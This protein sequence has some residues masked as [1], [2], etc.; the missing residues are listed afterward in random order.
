[1]NSSPKKKFY[2]TLVLGV[3]FVFALIFVAR[4]FL[5]MV[6]DSYTELSSF[7]DSKENFQRASQY[8]ADV[9]EES[10][11]AKEKQQEINK[12]FIEKNKEVDFFIKLEEIAEKTSNMIKISVGSLPK[13]KQEENA[14]IFNV[15]LAG[16]FSDLMRFLD[17]MDELT[18]FTNIIS[19]NTQR[20]D[21]TIATG[22]S[23]IIMQDNIEG[24]V[25][26][27]MI[28]KTYTK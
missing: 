17:A 27:S 25:K 18:Y 4:F 28:I 22:E 20:I 26:T 6:R 13:G 19:L 14:L 10:A 5:R 7:Y 23:G 16:S 21:K 11:L 1:M 15:N 8:L 2:I 9:S 3:V 24:N 12:N